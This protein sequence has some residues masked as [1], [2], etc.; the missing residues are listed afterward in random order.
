MKAQRQRRQPVERGAATLA[1][2][3]VLFFI[4]AMVAA[5][6]NRNM[7][8]EQRT[9]ANSYRAAQ[10]LGAAEAGID[11]SIMMLNGRTI[12]ADCTSTAATNDF[13]SRYLDLQQDGTFRARVW[14]AGAGAQAQPSCIAN[15]TTWVCSCPEGPPADL[16]AHLETSPVFASR[17]E[18]YDS[19]PGVMVLKTRG[20]DSAR[21]G[22]ISASNINSAGACHVE[23][24][25]DSDLGS[26]GKV[27]VDSSATIRVALGLASAMPVP[28]SA[29]MTV[30]GT[31]TQN[32]GTSLRVINPDPLTGL[33]IRAGGTIGD[34]TVIQTA[35][36]AGSTAET[37]KPLDTDLSAI[38]VADYFRQTFGLPSSTYGDQPAAVHASCAAGC[39]SGS[40]MIDGSLMTLAAV[41]AQNPTRVI[42]VSGNLTLDAPATYGSAD[43]PTVLVVTGDVTVTQAITFNGLLYVGGN[44]AWNAGASG[45]VINGALIVAGDYAGSGDAAIAYDRKIVQRIRYGYGSFVRIPGS[46]GTV[47]GK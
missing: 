13:R 20:C 43:T 34:S 21:S 18:P 27:A 26:S 10:A 30:R 40:M 28:P 3:M 37:E 12:G 5:Y 16:S 14:G 7:I 42:F 47:A 33:T 32:L 29:A 22:Q 15:G 4:L 23:R 38:A 9:S 8:F 31:V 35:G 1:V 6:T 36:P 24:V 41:S 45:G 25:D 19:R 46:W 2:V 44:L 17:F 11:W 39:T